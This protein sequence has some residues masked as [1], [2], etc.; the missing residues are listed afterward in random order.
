MDNRYYAF[1]C[2]IRLLEHLPWNSLLLGSA[3]HI[4][5]PKVNINVRPYINSNQFNLCN[6]NKEEEKAL[7]EEYEASRIHTH[8]L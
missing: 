1:V 3:Q 5:R 4:C 6:V 7:K 8:N 2:E